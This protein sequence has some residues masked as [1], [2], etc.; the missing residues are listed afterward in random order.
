M[1]ASCLGDVSRVLEGSMT[2][3]ATR[4]RQS[5]ARADSLAFYAG[6]AAL[7]LAIALQI[8]RR[9]RGACR[10]VLHLRRGG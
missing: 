9:R 3:T 1:R 2:M 6:L 10:P 5:A 7:L 8:M 4:D